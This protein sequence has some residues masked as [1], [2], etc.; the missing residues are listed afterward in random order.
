MPALVIKI[1]GSLL[2]R[3]PEIVP[4][5]R[6]SELPL[7]IVPGGGIFADAV[8][9]A[10]ADDTAAH[11]MAIAAM[12]QY[13]WLI[14]SNGLP[15]TAHVEV[16]R[17]TTVFLPYA[18]LREYDP[19]PHTWD[20]TSDSIAAW[21]AKTLGLNLILLKSID[22]IGIG[23]ILQERVSAPIKSDVVDPFFIQYVLENK[24]QAAIINGSDPGRLQD[25]L[26]GL[27]V[28]GTTIG[29]TF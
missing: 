24:I 11:W 27:P 19:L 21:V 6:A 22:G 15:A 26:M 13:G 9:R 18:S 29:T 17:H 25:F 23:G 10:K 2:S 28:P 20:I 5:L 8:R 14:S 1:G 12:E 16:P 7:L 4:A 3:I